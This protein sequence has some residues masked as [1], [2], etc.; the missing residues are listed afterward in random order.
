MIT[1]LSIRFRSLGRLPLDMLFSRL[2]LNG[3]QSLNSQLAFGMVFF[4][5]SASAGSLLCR[6]SLFCRQDCFDFV[7]P[8]AMCFQCH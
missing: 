5:G 7:K 1:Q 4:V 8:I 6:R 3:Q 2:E